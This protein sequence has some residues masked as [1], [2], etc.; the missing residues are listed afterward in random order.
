MEKNYADLLKIQE[1]KAFSVTEFDNL[2]FIV[3]IEM[4]KKKLT[5]QQ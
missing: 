4:L 5:Q 1:K 2:F 3:A